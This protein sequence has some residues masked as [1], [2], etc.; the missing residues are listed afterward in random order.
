MALRDK[1]KKVYRK[2]GRAYTI[3]RPQGD[4]TGEYLAQE[5]NTQATKPF[6]LLNFLRVSLPYDTEVIPGDTIMFEDGSYYLATVKL[7]DIF[8]G[9]PSC[10]LSVLY[11]CNDVA[12][13]MRNSESRDAD[14]KMTTTWNQIGTRTW[15]VLI[16]DSFTGEEIAANPQND[17]QGLF[18]NDVQDMYISGGCEIELG[19]RVALDSVAD[20]Y[21]VTQIK[22]TRYDNVFQITLDDDTR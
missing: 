21:M 18:K 7:P 4:I 10:F 11:R 2:V 22:K 15:P 12:T 1:I 9:A 3:I 6:V 14:L 13:I 8:K 16:A 20:Y 19:D 5:M 17:L